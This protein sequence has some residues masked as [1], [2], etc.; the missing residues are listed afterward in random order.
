MVGGPGENRALV[1]LCIHQA[2]VDRTDR[3]TLGAGCFAFSAEMAIVGLYGGTVAF[4]DKVVEVAET[5]PHDRNIFPELC[6]VSHAGNRRRDMLILKDPFDG[7]LV[8]T[9][10]TQDVRCVTSGQ[11]LHRND[12]DVGLGGPR[13]RLL[14]LRVALEIV[15]HQG[16]VEKPVL[17]VRKCMEHLCL[18]LVCGYPEET[19]FTLLF[20]S[21]EGF[22]NFRIEYPILPAGEIMEL[23]D[24]NV[25]RFKCLQAG[26]HILENVLFRCRGRSRRGLP[27]PLQKVGCSGAL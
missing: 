15:F 17:I 26:L 1:G 2:T 20:Q 10:W 4:Q 5:R 18:I 23:D 12:P 3:D 19:H 21:D 7:G 6:Q 13:N 14:G 11:R 27:L 9:E 8:G 22:P 25:V 16:R 24:I